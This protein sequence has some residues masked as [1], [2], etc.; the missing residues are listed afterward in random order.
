LNFIIFIVAKSGKLSKKKVMLGFW[1]SF[2]LFSALIFLPLVGEAAKDSPCLSCHEKELFKEA[3][4]EKVVRPVLQK[5][6]KDSVHREIACTECHRDV[7]A[8]PQKKPLT[9]VDCGTCHNNAARLFG[10]SVHGA[11]FKRG[12]KDAPDCITCH[13]D[14]RIYRVSDQRSPVSRANLMPLC[15]RCHTDIEVQKTH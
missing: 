10:R 14:H 6:M 11:A 1:L 12:D 15:V 8:L 5:D 13:G 4:G 7:A 9:K 2:L 3:G